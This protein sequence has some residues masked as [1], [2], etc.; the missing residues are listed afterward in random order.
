[1]VALTPRTEA[2][3]D[4]TWLFGYWPSRVPGKHEEGGG[5]LAS[6]DSWKADSFRSTKYGYHTTPPASLPGAPVAP[7]VKEMGPVT[8]PANTQ[9]GGPAEVTPFRPP[10]NGSQPSGNS[11]GDAS[12]RLGTLSKA[13]TRLRRGE[14]KRRRQEE[15][16]LARLVKQESLLLGETETVH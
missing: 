7:V 1:M 6:N 12:S 3:P 13:A 2:N 9:G 8:P 16:N 14:E 11:S 15:R 4:G 5:V 10:V